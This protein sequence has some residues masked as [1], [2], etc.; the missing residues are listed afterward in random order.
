M[1]IF[2]CIQ[3]TD[4]SKM[5]GILG[6]PS[7]SYLSKNNH[8][9]GYLLEKVAVRYAILPHRL[10]AKAFS[11]SLSSLLLQVHCHGRAPWENQPAVASED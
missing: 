8:Q 4:I 5:M 7:F 3:A 1:C 6:L 2:S 10:Q 9:L 11:Y